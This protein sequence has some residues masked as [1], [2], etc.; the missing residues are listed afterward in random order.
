MGKVVLG[1][2]FAFKSI[3]EYLNIF[4]TKWCLERGAEYIVQP[5][6]L[7]NAIN[8]VNGPSEPMRV[9]IFSVQIF[10]RDQSPFNETLRMTLFLVVTRP[11]PSACSKHFWPHSIFFWLYWIFL[12]GKI[13]LLTVFKKYVVHC[14]LCIALSNAYRIS[15]NSFRPW[16]VSSLE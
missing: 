8:N 16:I 5:N 4:Y 9:S 13:S 6:L 1:K 3:L 12:W 11:T 7:R 2:D 10:R 15:T 14:A